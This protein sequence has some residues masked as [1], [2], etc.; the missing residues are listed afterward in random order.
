MDNLLNRAKYVSDKMQF[1]IEHPDRAMT[2]RYNIN[3]V[4]EEMRVETKNKTF[5]QQHE[6]LENRIKE[7]S[8]C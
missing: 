3:S 8:G 4:L 7:M 6:A 1:L 5:I 2:C